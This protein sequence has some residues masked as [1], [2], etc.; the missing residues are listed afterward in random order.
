MKKI[1]HALFLLLDCEIQKCFVLVPF[2]TNLN[3]AIY[4]DFEVQSIIFTPDSE[5]R[6]IS[7]EV[8]YG[9]RIKS[10]IIS[11]SVTQLE[12]N[13]YYNTNDVSKIKIQPNNK[14]Y[15]S[16]YDKLIV[17]KSSPLKEQFDTLIFCVRIIKT[18][19]IPS[20]IE[21]IESHPFENCAS[22]EKVLF[23]S[24]SKLRII[25]K[26]AFSNSSLKSIIIPSTVTNLEEWWYNTDFLT[27]V[28]LM[29]NKKIL[30]NNLWW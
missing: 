2:F 24:N 27:E 20:S 26:Y 12:D 10:L 7:Q 3:F 25:K 8:F 11:S 18:I 1:K 22:I 13:W 9:S 29:P 4:S 5:L 14:H 21:I 30:I 28:K 23:E 15:I 16:I 19:P 17:S 6:T